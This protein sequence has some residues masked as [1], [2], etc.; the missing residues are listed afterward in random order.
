MVFHLAPLPLMT[1]IGQTQ[2]HSVF[3]GLYVRN[4]TRQAYCCY[5]SRIRSHIWSFIWHHDIW[6]MVTLKGQILGHSVFYRLYFQFNIYLM[7][8]KLQGHWSYFQLHPRSSMNGY[9]PRSLAD[10]N[11]FS[12]GGHFVTAITALTGWISAYIMVIY[13]VTRVTL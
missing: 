13:S 9:F 8:G 1:L 10:A 4:W 6:P 2:G 7:A 3:K 11:L 12:D 5:E